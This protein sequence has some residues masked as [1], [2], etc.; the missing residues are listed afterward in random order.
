MVVLASR[1][2]RPPSSMLHLH[3]RRIS[4]IPG[5]HAGPAPLPGSRNFLT[6]SAPLMPVPINTAVTGMYCLP[7]GSCL[8]F[9][10]TAKGT[11]SGSFIDFLDNPAWGHVRLLAQR[12]AIEMRSQGWSGAAMLPY[13]ELGILRLPPEHRRPGGTFSFRNGQSEGIPEKAASAGN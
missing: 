10:L 6:G 13:G 5:R 3:Q 4:A 8:G 1:P 9:S 2:R 11:F 7:L 12:E